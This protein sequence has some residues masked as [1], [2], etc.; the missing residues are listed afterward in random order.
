[1]LCNPNYDSNIAAEEL[2]LKIG[3]N[4]NYPTICF[5]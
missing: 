4:V 5:F 1:M 3:A 2:M